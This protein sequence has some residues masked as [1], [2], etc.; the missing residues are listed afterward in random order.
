MQE[1]NKR[2][3]RDELSHEELMI[4]SGVVEVDYSYDDLLEKFIDDCEM[5]N[6]REYTIKMVVRKSIFK[7]RDDL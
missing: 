1:K 7:R 3:R 6:L 4:L 2:G 5:R